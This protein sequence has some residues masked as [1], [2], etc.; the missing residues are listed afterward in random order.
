MREGEPAVSG[1]TSIWQQ[2][3]K[4][5]GAEAISLRVMEFEPGLSPGIR[6][7]DS[8]EVLYFFEGLDN[9]S[10]EA[11]RVTVYINGWAHEVEPQTGI[12]LPAGGTLTINNPGSKPIVFI[13]AQCPE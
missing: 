10:G 2:I 6:N 8:D 4:S 9:L 13:S 12:Y 7:E 11:S 3:G 5:I 1:T